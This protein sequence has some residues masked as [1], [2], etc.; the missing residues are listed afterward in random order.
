VL[1]NLVD[2][3]ISYTPAGGRVVVS[4]TAKG[5]GAEVSVTDTGSGIPVEYREHIFDRFS[6]VPGAQGRRRGF[7]LGLYFCR[8][9]VQAHGGQIWMESG[10]HD[11]G[12]RFFF[13]LPQNGAPH[14]E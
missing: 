7:G 1:G 6:Q 8:Q 5:T 11:I 2:N 9:V 3:A 14:P 12:S 13:T 4:A 10:P